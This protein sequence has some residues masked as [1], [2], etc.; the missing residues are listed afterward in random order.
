MFDNII[1]GFILGVLFVVVMSM[2]FDWLK[3]KAKPNKTEETETHKPVAHDAS[4]IEREEDNLR[5]YSADSY[6][7]K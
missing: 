7:R 1:G 4:Q 2:F 5:S 3:R 6:P